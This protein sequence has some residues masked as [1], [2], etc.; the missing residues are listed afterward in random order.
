M[1]SLWFKYY[2]MMEDLMKVIMKIFALALGLEDTFFER[3][4]KTHQ[5]SLRAVFYPLSGKG[6]DMRAGEHTDWGCV[7]ILKQ[8][9]KRTGGLQIKVH[10]DKWIDV[11]Y[12]PDSFVV[13]L[14]DL[15]PRWTN[16]KF[17]A[18]PHR[19]VNVDVSNNERLTIPFFG[20]VDG[21]T[22]VECIPSC[23]SSDN[24]AKYPPI[25]AKEFY[26]N[27]EK[28]IQNNGS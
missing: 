17:K 4:L 20:L 2:L 12:V 11:P 25:Q 5:S 9:L 22:L 13:N 19:V 28:Y 18:T 24:P 8:D 3:R 7:T 1:E 10:N 21:D 14:G 15:F 23:R 16:D 27:H 26:K 6:V